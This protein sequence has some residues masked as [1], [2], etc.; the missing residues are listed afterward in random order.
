MT[1]GRATPHRPGPRHVPRRHQRRQPS[2]RADGG[3]G[4]SVLRGDCVEVMAGMVVAV[5][6]SDGLALLPVGI[7][8]VPPLACTPG[9]QP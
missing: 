2:P 1:T 8:T 9:G 7:A 6:Q 3:P 5:L 4:M